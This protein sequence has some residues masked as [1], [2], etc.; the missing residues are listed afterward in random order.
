M[1][2]REGKTGLGTH[3]YVFADYTFTR[4]GDNR[5]YVF[6]AGND[7]GHDFKTLSE[8]RWWARRQASAT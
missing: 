8:A 4:M 3:A 2:S 7:T 6:L 5:W 1:T